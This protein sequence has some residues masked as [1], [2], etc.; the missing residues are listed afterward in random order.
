MDAVAAG[1]ERIVHFHRTKLSTYPPSPPTHMKWSYFHSN[2]SLNYVTSA[3]PESRGRW[4]GK[5]LHQRTYIGSTMRPAPTHTIFHLSG[6]DTLRKCS[7]WLIRTYRCVRGLIM[8]R[9][10]RRC[11]RRKF[12]KDLII[13]QCLKT[14]EDTCDKNTPS[15]I[16]WWIT[17]TATSL[18]TP[19]Q[20]LFHVNIWWVNHMAAIYSI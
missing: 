6:P 20:L 3:D 7:W 13:P 2:S 14:R 9:L 8:T 4:C 18:G 5:I 15:S 16:S 12:G 19:I 11:Q 10:Q 1:G 17:P